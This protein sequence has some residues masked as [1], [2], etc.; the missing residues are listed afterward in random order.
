MR[1]ARSILGEC[2]AVVRYRR[3]LAT[4]RHTALLLVGIGVVMAAALRM[5]QSDCDAALMAAL[6]V[7]MLWGTFIVCVATWRLL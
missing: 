3:I 7:A 5:L 2:I 1:A 4:L 6:F